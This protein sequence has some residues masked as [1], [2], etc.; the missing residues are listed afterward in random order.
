MRLF[1][2]LWQRVFAYAIL[3]V[4]VSH[5][6]TFMMFRLISSKE[7]DLRI[8]SEITAGIVSALDGR[9]M[10]SIE[11]L[12]KFFNNSPRK[13]WLELPGGRIAAGET[14]PEFT[15]PNRAGMQPVSAPGS[16]VTVYRSDAPDKPYFAQT[17]VRLK[18]GVAMAC[19]RLEGLPSPPMFTL[20]L[21][22]LTAVCIIGGAL[23]VWV[24][25]RI[26]RPLRRLRSEVLQIAEGDLEARVSERAPEEIAQVAGAVNHMAQSLLR[27]IRN[28]RELVANLSHEMRSPLARM[29]ISAAIIEEGLAALTRGRGRGGSRAP[30][31]LDA[32]GVPLACTHI[33][34]VVREIG[35]MEKLV[36]SSLLNSRLDLQ[37][38][39]LQRRP[40][41]MSALCMDVALRHE[42]LLDEKD[43]SLTLDIQ[44]DIWVVGDEPLLSLVLTNLLDNAVKY[45]DRGGLA[46]LV[47]RERS[48][49][50]RLWLENS[51][52]GLDQAVLADL[53]EPFFRGVAT[54]DA[55]GAGLGL[56]LVKKIAHCHNGSAGVE[57]CYIGLRFSVCLPSLTV[58]RDATAASA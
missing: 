57:P 3:L 27:N 29:S 32:G 30:L 50:V 24:T 28:M 21:A 36:G 49:T 51:H 34:Y 45:T 16:P 19:L 31:I 35:H 10:E 13:L 33:G 25:W 12:L 44:P 43:L 2:H 8:I 4:L 17:A 9:E 46:R 54:G 53:F 20:F 38:E 40:V 6:V 18:D 15:F 41:D 23:S 52:P 48:G 5:L 58:R 56:T 1:P 37:Q 22:G 42:A 7:M 26:A 47:L 39:A 11:A 14:D 55:E